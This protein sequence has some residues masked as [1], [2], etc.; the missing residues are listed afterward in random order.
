MFS[1][2]EL[3]QHARNVMLIFKVELV[4]KLV[5]KRIKQSLEDFMEEKKKKKGSGHFSEEPQKTMLEKMTQ[6]DSV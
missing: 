2:K 3:V 6:G 1:T 4:I 5:I